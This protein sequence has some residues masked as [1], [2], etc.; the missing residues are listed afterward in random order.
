MDLPVT[1]W[2]CGG[3]NDRRGLLY[4]HK[5]GFHLR[6]DRL[7]QDVPPDLA[8]FSVTTGYSSRNYGTDF[9]RDK[10]LVSTYS[11]FTDN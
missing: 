1:R 8:P 2:L 3:V 6:G 9:S 5:Q 10:K 11:L 4:S 7:E